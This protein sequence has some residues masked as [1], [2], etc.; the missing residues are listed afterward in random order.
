M[1]A[2]SRNNPSKGSTMQHVNYSIFKILVFLH[3][4]N[5]SCKKTLFNNLNLLAAWRRLDK[6]NLLWLDW[7]IR[8]PV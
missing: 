1:E 3:L 8:S 4:N 2:Q 5:P 6:S 7:E